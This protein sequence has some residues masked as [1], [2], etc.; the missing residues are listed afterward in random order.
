MVAMFRIC[1]LISTIY[2]NSYLAWGCGLHLYF[3]LLAVAWRNL[4]YMC[5][6][7]MLVKEEALLLCSLG[8]GVKTPFIDCRFLTS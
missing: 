5:I 6:Y 2:V 7:L 3:I 1:L 4:T 8:P